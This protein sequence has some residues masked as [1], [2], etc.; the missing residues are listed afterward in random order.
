[1]TAATLTEGGY[2]QLPGET[3]WWMPSG[4]VFYSPGRQ[5]HARPGTGQPPGP[6]L[7]AAPGRRPVRRDHPGRLRRHALLPVTVTDPVGNVTAAANDYRVLQPA[8]VTDP[9]G[10]RV[11]AA[12]DALGQVTATAVMGKTTETA[13]DLL[14]GFT[15]DLDDATLL[16]AVR[17][18]AGRPGRHP[19]QRDQPVPLRP[20]RLPADRTPGR[21]PRRRPPTP[22]PARP[23]SP[24]WPR[25]RPTPAPRRPRSTSTT[26]PTSTA[27][28]GRSSTRPRPRPARSPTAAR[29]CHRAGPGPAGRSST[30]RDGRS[31]STSRSSRRPTPS[32]SPRRPASA[33]SLFYD[34]PG[35]VVATLHPDS[36]WEKTVFGPWP[37]S[38]GTATT[39]C[40]SPIR[41][42]T[43]TSATTSS[44]CSAP[45]PFTSWYEL[46]IGGTY[47]ATAQDQAAQQDAAQKAAAHAATPAVSHRDSAGRVCLAVADNGGGAR[48]PD[49][50]RLRHRGQAAR[51][52][53]RAGPAG[54]GIR[55]P[56]PAAGRRIA[57][58]GRQRHGRPA[59][60]PGQR[61][62]RRA[63]RP[64][65]TSP[66]SRSAAG[67]R[68]ATRSASST[69]RRSARPTATSA[70]P[71]PPRSSST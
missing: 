38:S 5:R 21:S 60:L 57:V 63:A 42:P 65:R 30:T 3:G 43:P 49:P 35:R 7:P 36:S 1:M 26:S 14:T 64:D 54:G 40:W 29:R 15:A 50:H 17:R 25:R 70:R 44:G 67:T 10:N 12:F 52:L 9:N 47:G 41:A 31:A 39:P 61:R 45:A 23:T 56:R 58:P 28:A 6:V 55:L 62:R 2:V 34:P 19:G 68:A 20:R 59:P 16:A 13:G 22:W 18:P 27:S 32:S 4:Q 53:R 71:A 69:I 11:A 37:S 66:A 51:R 8:T 46:R 24:T 33:R 48:Y